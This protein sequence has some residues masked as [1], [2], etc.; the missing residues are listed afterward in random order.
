MNDISL[1]DKRETSGSFPHLGLAFNEWLSNYMTAY[2]T[3]TIPDF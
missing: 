1:Q 3:K 2:K